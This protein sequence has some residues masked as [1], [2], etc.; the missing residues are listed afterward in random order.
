MTQMNYPYSR[1][2]A[3]SHS[4]LRLHLRT[5]LTASFPGPNAGRSS[6][7]HLRL[8]EQPPGHSDS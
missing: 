1:S 7:L 8:Q 3:Q 6:A 5:P 2:E 4:L